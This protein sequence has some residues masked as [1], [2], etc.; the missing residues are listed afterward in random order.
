MSSTQP[1]IAPPPA[2][3]V[4][5]ANTEDYWP[6]WIGL[7]WF[8][9]IIGTTFW[10]LEVA[11]VYPWI[12]GHDFLTTLSPYNIG[13]MALIVAATLATMYLVHRCMNKEDALWQYF[14]IIIAVIICKIIGNQTRIHNIGLGDSV[15]CIVA[16][17]FMRFVLGIFPDTLAQ[18][19]KVLSLEFFIKIGIVLLAIN[20]REIGTSGP[21]GL[22][23]AWV[24]TSILIV[25]IYFTGTLLLKMDADSAIVTSCGVSICGSSAAVA[26]GDSIEVDK[27]VVSTLITIMSILTIPMIPLLPLIARLR[28]FNAEVTGAWIGGC[29]DSTGAVSASASLG[30][31]DVLHAAI[32]IK[33]LQNVL[34]GPVTLIITAVWHGTLRFRLLWDKFPKFVFGFIA[35]AIITTVLPK[36]IEPAVMANAFVISEWFSSIS[37]VLIGLD[38]DLWTIGPKMW[39]MKKILILYCF[40]Q[41]ID[42]FTTLGTAELM[43]KVIH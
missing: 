39:S 38:I 26:I 13:G 32:I 1:L 23:V 14:V 43:F 29:V 27:Q 3:K 37:F 9:A 22:T 16:G 33:M 35:T 42:I 24:E 28:K 2:P 41:M 21:R 19:K 7:F 20:L 10:G 17:I 18:L 31:I 11:H 40:G 5:F 12:S 6:V 30:G 4:F 36:H 25:G 8:G 15:W 34:I